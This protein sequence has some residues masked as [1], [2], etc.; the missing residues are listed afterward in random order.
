MYSP[1]RGVEQAVSL[2]GEKVGALAWTHCHSRQITQKTPS[3]AL[4]DECDGTIIDEADLHG[5]TKDALTGG[6]T[7]CLIE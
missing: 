7:M 6:H 4:K 2:W 5:R 1:I 3:G